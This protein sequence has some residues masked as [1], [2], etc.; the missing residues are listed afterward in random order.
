MYHCISI[1]HN[2]SVCELHAFSAFNYLSHYIKCQT[3]R[4]GSGWAGGRPVKCRP[5]NWE[6]TTH[7]QLG[8]GRS[9]TTKPTKRSELTLSGQTRAT[10]RRD[11][12]NMVP[13]YEGGEGEDYVEEVAKY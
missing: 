10:E 3:R 4:G 1:Q 8:G 12:D 6:L 9:A 5:C 2:V 7:L 13:W 11:E